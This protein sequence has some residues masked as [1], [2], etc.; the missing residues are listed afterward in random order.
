L[1][2]VKR[3]VGDGAG[4]SAMSTRIVEHSP[5]Q[6]SIAAL[7]QQQAENLIR[8]VGASEGE[9]P[10]HK[11]Y[12]VYAVTKTGE[13]VIEQLPPDYLIQKIDPPAACFTVRGHATRS[14]QVATREIEEHVDEL[15]QRNGMIF[16][17]LVKTETPP[18]K[19]DYWFKQDLDPDGKI[20]HMEAGKWSELQ[21]QM[22]GGAAQ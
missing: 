16:I 11:Y 12:I 6:I 3:G 19:S 13:I 4:G 18:G 2:Y 14:G 10:E 22:G 20:L 15:C 21:D 7:L 1:G 5:W 8:M 17:E 9:T